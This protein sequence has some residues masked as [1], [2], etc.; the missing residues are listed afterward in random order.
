MFRTSLALASSR[1]KTARFQNLPYRTPVDPGGFHDHVGYPALLQPLVQAT[2][3]S[4]G[5]PIVG[6]R[7]LHRSVRLRPD[8]AYQHGLFVYIYA[9]APL[10]QIPQRI[11]VYLARTSCP[12]TCC[13]SLAGDRDTARGN[14]FRVLTAGGR[15]NSVWC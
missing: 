2:Q 10:I 12:W 9:R 15:G 14:L 1:C 4:R 13:A 7:A 11:D 6:H 3:F 5:G 8:H